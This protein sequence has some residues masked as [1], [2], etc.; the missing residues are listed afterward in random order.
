MLTYAYLKH[1]THEKYQ[2]SKEIS[3]C[4]KVVI[5]KL[6]LADGLSEYMTRIGV[7]NSFWYRAEWSET[8]NIIT[9]DTS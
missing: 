5:V 6:V 4:N 8:W 1:L 3:P 9:Q 7:A 2:L